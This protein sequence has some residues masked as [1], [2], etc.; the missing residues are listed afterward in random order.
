MIKSKDNLKMSRAILIR[1]DDIC[2]TMN[3]KEWERATRLLEKHN[4]K[5]LLGVIPDCQDTNLMID[6]PREDF[7]EYIKMLQNDGYAIAMHGYKHKYDTVVHGIVNHTPHSEFAGHTY[8]EQYE[9]IRK[10]KKILNQHGI[11]TDIFFAPAHSYDENTLQALAANGFKYL[12]D[13]KSV[14]PFWRK[15]ILCIPCRASGCPRIRKNGYYTAVFHAHTWRYPCYSYG[16][17]QFE[18]LCTKYSKN[19]VPFE[20]YRK[21]TPGNF[22]IQSIDEKIYILIQYTLKPIL[23]AFVEL[24]KTELFTTQ[25]ESG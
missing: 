10:G 23:R 18:T 21:Q 20:I 12:S 14:K 5:P 25:R 7:W 11:D 24:I 16:Y 2:P 17:D 22:L 8:E 13:G 6:S 1:F 19:I 9:K 4:I 3:W 15:G